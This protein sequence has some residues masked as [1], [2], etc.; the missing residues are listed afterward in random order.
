MES[1]DRLLRGHQPE[2]ATSNRRA[3]SSSGTCRDGDLENG[4]ASSILSRIRLHIV[5]LVAIGFIGLV[6]GVTYS[7]SYL[8]KPV[9][10]ACP[11][12]HR[13]ATT[14]GLSA[15]GLGWALS[16]ALSMRLKMSQ[17]TLWAVLGI[18]IMGV[19]EGIAGMMVLLCHKMHKVGEAI[20]IA[21][22]V[23]LSIGSVIC[24][25]TTT[26]LALQLLPERPG[27]GGGIFSVCA[28]V[29]NVGFSQAMIV[30]RGAAEDHH[31]NQSILFFCLGISIIVLSSPWIK[32]LPCHIEV[33]KLNTIG[34]W[35]FMKSG[36][37]VLFAVMC[38]CAYLPI[39]AIVMHQEPLMIA[40]WN[41]DQPPVKS[42]SAVLTSLYIIGR[43][44][45]C[46]ASDRIGLKRL[47]FMSF[48]AQSLLLL[49]L[50][51]LITVDVQHMWSRYVAIA[52]LGSS[53]LT[54]AVFKVS[55]GGLCDKLYSRTQR[56]SALGLLVIC[57]G[58]ACIAGPV[59]IEKSYENFGSYKEFLY[60]SAGLSLIGLIITLLL[61]RPT[62]NTGNKD[63]SEDIDQAAKA[64]KCQADS[65]D[66]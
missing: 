40:L 46:T 47:W 62:K 18:V 33:Q 12:W 16:A 7:S 36:R 61:V 5:S 13:S 10:R 19:T 43:V 9:Q 4:C 63:H 28:G 52:I 39:L 42:L 1:K 17:L 21:T 49:G 29:G 51:V 64:I 31:L 37:S 3:A 30:L 66:T 25:L 41:T 14:Y 23:L 57:S 58:L 22:F 60:G 56:V 6:S 44:F 55:A 38:F 32:V 24:Y 45:G 59:T 8:I 11:P 2:L 27:L 15:A 35:A 20:Y 50:A 34:L 54:G 53:T 26:E 48:L 65:R